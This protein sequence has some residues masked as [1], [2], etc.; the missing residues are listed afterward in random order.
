MEVVFWPFVRACFN[1]VQAVL[2]TCLNVNASESVFDDGMSVS[3]GSLLPLCCL[4]TFFASWKVV[5]AGNL[6][7]HPLK[8]E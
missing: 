4:A 1:I 5:T 6:E 2:R 7:D 3:E 8:Y